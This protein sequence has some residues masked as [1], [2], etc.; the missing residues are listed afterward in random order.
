MESCENLSDVHQVLESAQALVG[1]KKPV[2]AVLEPVNTA[3]NLAFAVQK[4][5]AGNAIEADRFIANSEKL[6]T[7]SVESN[8]EYELEASVQTSLTTQYLK[9]AVLDSRGLHEEAA[10]ALEEAES[11]RNSSDIDG[12]SGMSDD[13]FFLAEISSTLSNSAHLDSLGKPG[14]AAEKIDEAE[15]LL[16]DERG[17]WFSSSYT[18]TESSAESAVY[19][20]RVAHFLRNGKYSEA[21]IELSR[22]KQIVNSI[23]TWD[24]PAD[25]KL[26][27]QVNY[28]LLKASVEKYSGDCKQ[29]AQTYYDAEML[30]RGHDKDSSGALKAVAAIAI[31]RA[32]G[33]INFELPLTSLLLTQHSL[34]I[35][36]LRNGKRTTTQR[37]VM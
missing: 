27:L 4:E 19:G 25:T 26:K 17:S 21:A 5:L 23:S 35:T 7:L 16:A 2:A 3:I 37:D 30:L 11:L 36:R 24:H 28:Y 20:A 22:M 8:Y 34:K 29:S 31:A 1:D 6:T 15:E 18:E 14:L 32:G 9:A 33:G 13:A 12:V 10:A